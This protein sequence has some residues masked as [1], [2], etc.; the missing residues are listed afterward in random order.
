MSIRSHDSH[1]TEVW[2]CSCLSSIFFTTAE[3]SPH[4]PFCRQSTSSCHEGVTL[5]CLSHKVTIFVRQSL[6][7]EPDV[8]LTTD[9]SIFRARPRACHWSFSSAMVSTTSWWEDSPVRG[10][11]GCKCYLAACWLS[12]LPNLTQFHEFPVKCTVHH[13]SH[14]HLYQP[15]FNNSEVRII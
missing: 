3:L 5:S 11:G 12:D 9:G 13:I 7:V 15:V 1:G 2:P 6:G 4:R 10:G 14:M 8:S